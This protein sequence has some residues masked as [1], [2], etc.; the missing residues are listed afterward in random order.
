MSLLRYFE[1][2][3]KE[4]SQSNLTIPLPS[5]VKSLSKKE[6]EQVNETVAAKTVELQRGPGEQLSYND[7][8]P[9]QRAMIG[10]YAAEN[11]ATKAS[12]HFSKVLA[13][14]VPESTARRLRSQYLAALSLKVQAASATDS[15]V[16]VPAVLC[17]AKKNLVD[18]FS[19]E[20]I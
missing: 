13:K 14:N 18:L 3:K 1:K 9:E 15:Q 2:T 10:K 5:T 6:L 20:K 11:G 19:L 12:R 7:Y 17:L 8:S 16:T 4:P